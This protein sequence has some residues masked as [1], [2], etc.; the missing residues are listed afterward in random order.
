M[1]NV[2]HS[3]ER[4]RQQE[5]EGLDPLIP[6]ILQYDALKRNTT[7][8]GF[9]EPVCKCLETFINCARTRPVLGKLLEASI[10]APKENV[11]RADFRSVVPKATPEA[12]PTADIFLTYNL[13]VVEPQQANLAS[14]KGYSY[15]DQVLQ[16]YRYSRRFDNNFPTHL[17]L[18]CGL[19]EGMN[20]PG[21]TCRQILD[22]MQLTLS[23]L[24]KQDEVVL[25]CTITLDLHVLMRDVAAITA[26]LQRNQL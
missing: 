17:W 15:E 21:Y 8:P 12:L 26:L 1:S 5:S 23:Y 11:M 2:I 10:H 16:L 25:V 24:S 3:A 22:N 7:V 13:E 14:I 6:L 18:V 20:Y 19:L 9:S 4:F